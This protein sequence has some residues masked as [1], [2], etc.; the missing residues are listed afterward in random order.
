MKLQNAS[1]KEILRI[2]VGS[3]VCLALMLA[4]FFALSFAKIVIFD[5][6]VILGG[7]AGT[8]VA[9]GN[10]TLLC[11]TIQNAAG[12]DNKKQMRARFQLSY[13]IRLI[14]Q[15]AW[16]VAAFLAPCFRVV[17]AALPLLFPTVVIYVLQM[18][19]KLVTPST[20]ENPTGEEPQQ[21]ERL[22]TFEA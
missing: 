17:A 3:C 22:D 15:A 5:Y 10:F 21:E 14:A 8:L 1:K 13:N 2:A 18:T 9:V 6:R 16:V 19:G 7:V 4:A 12:I 11:L 20:R